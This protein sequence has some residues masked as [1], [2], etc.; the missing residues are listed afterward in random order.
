MFRPAGPPTTISSSG[1][2]PQYRECTVA[3]A[4]RNTERTVEGRD[5]MGVEITEATAITDDVVDAFARLIPQLSS[6]SPAPSRVELEAIVAHDAATLLLARDS[7]GTLLGSMTLITFPP[8]GKGSAR[9]S[10]SEP[11]RSPAKRA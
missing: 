8:A 7:D 1:C 10:I 9:R 6:S 4:G 5:Q 11:S 2:C 3:S